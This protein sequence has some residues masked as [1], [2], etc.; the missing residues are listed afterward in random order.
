MVGADV[1]PAGVRPDVV[2]PIGD[3]LA[4][5]RVGE[6]VDA[7]QYGIT[8]RPPLSA[9]GLELSDEFLLP[10][11]HADYRLTGVPVLADLLV[12][13]A[14]LGV[15]IRVPAALQG[16]DVGLQ[17]EAFLPQQAGDGVGADL[18]PGPGQLP[19]TLQA[20]SSLRCSRCLAARGSGV[21]CTTLDT[22]FR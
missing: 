19:G 18:A 3:S 6:V 8:R 10:G 5:L 17:A 11:V 15:T 14:E 12:E 22:Q 9:T 16:C 4:Q 20:S 21:S 7:H 2:D 1:D 13:M